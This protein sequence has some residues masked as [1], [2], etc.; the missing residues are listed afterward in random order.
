MAAFEHLLEARGIGGKILR[1]AGKWGA[2][3]WDR[4]PGWLIR[5]LLLLIELRRDAE[6]LDHVAIFLHGAA[7]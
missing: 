3:D 5:S 6:G 4:R 7:E 2:A 1:P